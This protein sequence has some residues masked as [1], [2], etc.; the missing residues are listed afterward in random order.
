MMNVSVVSKS[1][2]DLIMFVALV[3]CGMLD[4]ES[5]SRCSHINLLVKRVLLKSVNVAALCLLFLKM[6]SSRYI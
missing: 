2:E 1:F 6:C 3:D 4:F 5:S